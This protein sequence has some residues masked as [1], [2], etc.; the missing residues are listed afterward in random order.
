MTPQ[1][2]WCET[3]S[4]ARRIEKENAEHG[5]SFSYSTFINHRQVS[6]CEHNGQVTLTLFKPYTAGF[7]RQWFFQAL[8]HDPRTSEKRLSLR[9]LRISAQQRGFKLP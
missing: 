1:E 5:L 4:N 2:I 8:A 3:Y 6:L 9:M 7:Y